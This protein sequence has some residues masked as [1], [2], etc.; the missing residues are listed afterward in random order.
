M[1]ADVMVA[2]DV[3]ATPVRAMKTSYT[4]PTRAGGVPGFGLISERR[5]T[6]PHRKQDRP[7]RAVLLFWNAASFTAFDAFNRAM[8]ISNTLQACRDRERI[9]SIVR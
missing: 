9:R 4:P 2:S 8:V 1:P 5:L 3:V 6:E 7:R